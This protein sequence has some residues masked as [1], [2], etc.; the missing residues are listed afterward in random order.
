MLQ[1]I[2]EKLGI[3]VDRTPKCTPEL[4][5]EGIEYCWAMAK[6]WYR[7][8][9]LKKKRSKDNFHGLVK[10]CLGTEIL[11]VERARMFSRRAR[12]YM[13]LYLSLDDDSMSPTPVNLDHLNN[14][15]K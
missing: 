13:V 15:R 6:G 14:E 8:Q 5:G 7:R 12:E 9:P 11:S 2:G 10:E 3:F 1:H 4:A